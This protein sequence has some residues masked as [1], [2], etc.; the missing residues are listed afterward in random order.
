M[1]TPVAKFRPHYRLSGT[2]IE[3][4]RPHYVWCNPL[5]QPVDQP[6][7]TGRGQQSNALDAIARSN[8]VTVDGHGAWVYA[9][10][11]RPAGA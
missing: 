1:K 10:T 6:P 7:A 4:G 9:A 3:T 2:N 11:G 5:P 8:R